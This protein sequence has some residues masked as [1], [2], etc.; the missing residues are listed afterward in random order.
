MILSN[1]NANKDCKSNYL[2]ADDMIGVGEPI[3]EE[4]LKSMLPIKGKAIIGI[5]G[6]FNINDFDRIAG[7]LENV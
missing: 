4:L 3:P 5:L 1:M 6:A 2:F 7:G